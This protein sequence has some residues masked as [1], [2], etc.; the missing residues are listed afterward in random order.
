MSD[1]TSVDKTEGWAQTVVPPPATVTMLQKKVLIVLPWLKHVSPIT[2][3]CV[4]QLSDKRRTSTVLNFGDAFVAHSRN[5][6]ADAFLK[7]PCEY[8]FTIDDDMII[9]FGHAKWFNVHTGF[10]LPDKF[11]GLNAI[12]RLL[13]HQKTLVG[14]LYFGRQRSGVGMFNESQHPDMN[15]RIRSGSEDAI[16]P[17]KWVGTGCMLVHRSVYEDIEKKFPRLGRRPDGNG[18][19]WFSSSEHTAMD[20]I[21]RTRSMLSAGPMDGEKALKAFTML[22]SAAN[23]ARANSCITNGEDVTFCHRAREAG[24]QAFVDLGLLCGHIGHT[25]FGP[26][27]TGEPKLQ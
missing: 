5:S 14:G 3:F 17:T 13:S 2:S 20:W 23:E 21:D 19:N 9:P 10:N 11:A 25:V 1:L 7:S 12:D 26:K 27:N 8:M 22:E 16:I 6:C 15:R 18:G 4:A 24:H